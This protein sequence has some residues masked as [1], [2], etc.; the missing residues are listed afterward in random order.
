MKA[1]VDV[2]F[3]WKSRGVIAGTWKN[4]NAFMKLSLSFQTISVRFKS[5]CEA[6]CSLQ[7][8]IFP[9]HTYI[10]NVKLQLHKIMNIFPKNP[11]INSSK[12][13][14]KLSFQVQLFIKSFYPKMQRESSLLF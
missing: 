10:L 6:L 7:V 2:D 12:L 9:L 1:I 13:S 8:D 14:R 3:S 11:L 5:F 4:V